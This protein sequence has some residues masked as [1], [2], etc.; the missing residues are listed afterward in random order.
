MEKIFYVALAVI[1]AAGLVFC[2]ACC[3]K[4]GKGE[5]AD[6]AAQQ[7]GETTDGTAQPSGDTTDKTAPEDTVKVDPAP[8]YKGVLP[9]SKGINVNH[10]ETFLSDNP[11]GFFEIGIKTVTNEATYTNIKS[12]GFDYVRLPVNFYSAYYEAATG[13]YD[14]TT[15]QIMGYIDTAIDL[16]TK[17][18]LYVMLDFHGWFYIGQEQDDYEQFLYCWTQVA[19]R[20]KDYSH[21][22]VFELL[23]EPWYTNGV[24]QPYLSDSRLNEMQADAIKIIRDTGSKNADRLIVCCTADGNKAWKLDKLKLPDDKNLAVAIHEYDPDAFTGQGFTWSGKELGAQVRLNPATDMGGVKY[25][26]SQIKK[27]M[28]ENPDVPIVLNEFGLNLDLAADEDVS[29]YLRYIT[30][31]C[32]ENGIPWAYWQYDGNDY[33]K[34]LDFYWK[35]REGEFALYRQLNTK[36]VYDWDVLALNAL[37]LR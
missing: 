31:F 27:F 36:G 15:E 30:K 13:D 26:F 23:N 24:A 35:I 37:F 29:Y 2:L 9:F 32:M 6:S 18:G 5:P 11:W 21:M 16:A 7:S 10:M 33:S 22:L 17:N 1:V 4:S 19:N 28:I 8:E 34:T 25:D 3:G 12:Q 20:Y 14:Y